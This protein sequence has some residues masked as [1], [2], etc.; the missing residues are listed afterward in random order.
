MISNRQPGWSLRGQQCGGQEAAMATS[1][2]VVHSPRRD[3]RTQN[4]GRAGRDSRDFFRMSQMQIAA[5][6]FARRSSR[7]SRRLPPLQFFLEAAHRPRRRPGI[8]AQKFR[9]GHPRDPH[10]LWRRRD[11][12]QNPSGIRRAANPRLNLERDHGKFCGV[13]G[14]CC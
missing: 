1:P 3:F 8:P 10:T 11:R 7:H 13:E 9:G 4:R 14:L 5:H 2:L 6:R 12:F